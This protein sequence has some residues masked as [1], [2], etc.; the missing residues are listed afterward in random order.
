MLKTQLGIGLGSRSASGL[1]FGLVKI[2]VS[3][4]IMHKN[5]RCTKATSVMFRAGI[6]LCGVIEDDIS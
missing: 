5:N 6:V 3:N 1:R 4:P 2:R